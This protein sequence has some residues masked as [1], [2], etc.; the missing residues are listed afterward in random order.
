VVSFTPRP[1]YPQGKSLWYPL[2]RKLDNIRL[3]LRESVWEG[4]EWVHVAQDRDQ[5]WDL[6]ST[7]MDFQVP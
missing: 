6:V 1:L 2:D 4:V 5:W 3:N 7:V